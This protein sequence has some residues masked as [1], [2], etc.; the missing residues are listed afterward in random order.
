MTWRLRTALSFDDDVVQCLHE[1]DETFGPSIGHRY[2]LLIGTGL[3]LIAED[4]FRLGS[5]PSDVIRD[6]RLLHLRR[7]R[8]EAARIGGGIHRPRHMIAYQVD[9]ADHVVVALRLLH[10]A[11]DIPRHLR[12]SA[13]DG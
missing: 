10:E 11:M 5:T 3:T 9:A 2:A 13:V 8:R 1:S 12:A 6:V 7:A 4:P